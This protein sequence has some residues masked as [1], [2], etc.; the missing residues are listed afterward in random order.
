MRKITPKDAK[1]TKKHKG[2]WFALC[3]LCILMI[4]LPAAAQE[5]GKI[6]PISVNRDGAW[7][8]AD[9]WLPP[10]LSADG[11][12]VY[13]TTLA[14]NLI[15]GA[16]GPSM[17]V[18]LHDRTLSETQIISVSTSG[19]PWV[20][21]AVSIAASGN[22]RFLI[23]KTIEGNQIQDTKQYYIYDQLQHQATPLLILGTDQKPLLEFN[24]V[25]LSDDGRFLAFESESSNLVLN[26]NNDVSDIFIYDRLTGHLTRASVSSNGGEANAASRL[27]RISADGRMVAFT[28]EASNLVDSSTTACWLKLGGSP[29][30]PI[31]GRQMVILLTPKLAPA[32]V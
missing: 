15:E 14:A 8:N 23:F 28:S 9:S 1:N 12:F 2:I 4:G 25:S 24:E 21:N 7:G 16:T 17:K 13:Y 29:S 22:G 30:R 11:R 32:E 6:I 26:D 18:L 10:I 19:D 31:T 27:P 3:V 5:T 20:D